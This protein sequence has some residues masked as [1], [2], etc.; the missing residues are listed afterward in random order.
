MIRTRLSAALRARAPFTI[1]ST[2]LLVALGLLAACGPSS[3]VAATGVPATATPEA[4]VVAAPAIAARGE[5]DGGA[6]APPTATGASVR[7]SLARVAAQDAVEHIAAIAQQREQA[8]AQKVVTGDPHFTTYSDA[9]DLAP[10]D[11]PDPVVERIQMPAAGIDTRVVTGW[12]SSQKNVMLA[13]RGP[14]PIAWY[15]YSAVPGHGGNAV[16]AGH[17][18]YV[19]VGSAALGNLYKMQPGDTIQIVMTDGTVLTYRVA[20]NRTY[21]RNDGPWTTIFSPHD[22]NN[23]IT[24]YTCSGNFVGGDYSNRR[25]VRA[26]RVG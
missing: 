8:L 22:G 20:W 23:V 2:L 4:V 13:P 15:G 26:V 10:S 19:N 6:E 9:H 5:I 7:G 16:F 3:G 11:T 21:S 18:D 17:Y 25:V 14:W 24:V 1:A 12:I